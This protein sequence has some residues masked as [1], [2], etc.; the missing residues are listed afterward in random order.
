MNISAQEMARASNG[1]VRRDGK[2]GNFQFDTRLIEAG[3]WFLALQGA[4]DGHDFIPVARQK[5]CAGVIGQRV[6]SDWDRGFV[7]VSNTLKAFQDIASF[8]RKSFSGPVIGITGSAGKTTTRA[9]VG[10]TLEY[11]GSVHQTNGNFNNHIGVP[12]TI[13]DAPN[14][15]QA[16]VLEMGM[17][18]PGEISLLQEIA[19]PTVR[20]ITNIGAAHV[21][22]CGSIEGVAKAK[23][24]LFDGANSGDICCVNT[25]DHRV[26]AHPVPASATTLTYGSSPHC[27]IQLLE[28]TVDGESLC[29]IVKIHT[30]AGVIDSY[31]PIP[32][33]FMALNACA[34]VAVGYACGIPTSSLAESLTKYK[35]VGDRMQITMIGKTRFIND[36]YNANTLSMNAALNSLDT[37][38]SP[39]K[40]VLLGDMLEMGEEEEESHQSVLLNAISK[41]FQIGLVGPRFANAAKII[42]SADHSRI[43]WITQ[44]SKEMAQLLNV[45]NP[46]ERT[47]LLKGSRG[48]KMEYII[49]NYTAESHV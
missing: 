15:S 36:S 9:M 31:I 47:I 19:R 14:D 5:N 32:G 46:V 10:H 39:N 48:M 49:Q 43:L 11:L 8:A 4:R 17:N 40:I 18:A 3:Q 21:E 45:Q 13:T 33:K 24:E 41:G 7:E 42:S 23:G 12:K 25:D 35:P 28:S 29:T 34:A 22:G 27:D 38:S 2:A 6:P 44:T 20:L 26:A 16:W 30:P 1:T 37:I